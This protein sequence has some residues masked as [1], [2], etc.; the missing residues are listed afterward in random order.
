MPLR[1]ISGS[2]NQKWKR[3]AWLDMLYLRNQLLSWSSCLKALDKEASRLNRPAF[4]RPFAHVPFQYGGTEGF[5][6]GDDS[7]SDSSSEFEE[8]LDIWPPIN[9]TRYCTDEKQDTRELVVTEVKPYSFDNHSPLTTTSFYVRRTGI[10][11]RGR[12]QEI[13]KDYNEKIQECTS[14]I[15]GMVMSTQWVRH[16]FH[17]TSF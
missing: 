4:R 13:M 5:E 17:R 8:S 2:A 10:K 1:P 11:I 7:S 12:L 14:G 6:P 9:D 15:E 16:P 3:S